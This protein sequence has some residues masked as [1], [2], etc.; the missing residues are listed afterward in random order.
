MSKR[1]RARYAVANSCA[2]SSISGWSITRR[3]ASR[4]SW[5]PPARN[6]SCRSP[7]RSTTLSVPPSNVERHGLVPGD[8]HQGRQHVSISPLRQLNPPLESVAPQE[9]RLDARP[10]ELLAGVDQGLAAD[11]VEVVRGTDVAVDSHG[12]P[13]DE[14][15]VVR[16]QEP[17]ETHR[18]SE[19]RSGRRRRAALTR[20]A[21]PGRATRAPRTR[22]RRCRQHARFCGAWP[23]DRPRK[24]HVRSGRR[25]TNPVSARGL[26]LGLQD[27]DDGE[28]VVRACP[29]LLVRRPATT[30]HFRTRRAFSRA[31]RAG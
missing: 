30:V 25:G 1:S 19:V 9:T 10:P 28:L 22:R 3:A 16:P 11:E 29:S 27:S 20:A 31:R 23:R 21:S 17:G 5:A 6:L 2:R 26:R 24:P 4:R 15:A 14:G 18:G 13:S 8:R 12:E 7:S